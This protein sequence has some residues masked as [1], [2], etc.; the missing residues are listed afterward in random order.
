MIESKQNHDV[1]L[2]LDQAFGLFDHHLGDLNVAGG[3]F[4]EGRGNHLAGHRSL[5]VG[6]LFRALVDEQH[7][8]GDLGVVGGDRIGDRLQ[9]HGL[10]GAR[11]RHQETALALAEG[12]HEIHDPRGHIV[13]H[14]EPD[15]VLGI[16]RRQVV[17]VDLLHGHLWRLEVDRLDLDQ[18]EVALT[19]LGRSD[20]PR[21]RVTGV[22]VEAADLRRRDVNVVRAR[23]VVVLRRPE[24]AEALRQNLEYALTEDQPLR[25]GLV[26]ED[27]EDQILAAHPGRVLDPEALGRRAQL[28]DA[29]LLELVEV[30]APLGS[31]SPQALGCC[32]YSS[33]SSSRSRGITTAS[34][35]SACRSSSW[36]PFHSLRCR[37]LHAI[38]H[39]VDTGQAT[40]VAPRRSA[41]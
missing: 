14:L 20:L 16:Q 25:L 33:I 30:E 24:K 13:G 10:A 15:P 5:H 29:H 3:G 8:Q 31:S 2:V 21:D 6:D 41:H 39:V 22:E 35:S 12:R 7:D 36:F 26:L 9:H 34:S 28:A 40:R 1:A 18:S 19:L 4:V 38:H 37:S 23:E 11:R 27:A 32:S 17:E